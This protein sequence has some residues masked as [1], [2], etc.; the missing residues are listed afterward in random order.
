MYQPANKKREN[1][2]SGPITDTT[3]NK[4]DQIIRAT[5]EGEEKK[6]SLRRRINFCTNRQTGI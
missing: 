5:R 1:I 4:C 3:D 6:L 2:N